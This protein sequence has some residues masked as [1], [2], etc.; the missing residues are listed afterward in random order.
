MVQYLSASVDMYHVHRCKYPIGA[1][2]WLALYK[3]T[4]ELIL[5]T[6][7]SN[8]L[9]SFNESKRSI[10][11]DTEPL[12]KITNCKTAINMK[13]IFIVRW[14][15]QKTQHSQWCG[16][17]SVFLCICFDLSVGQI[18]K[19]LWINMNKILTDVR[20]WFRI[21]QNNSTMDKNGQHLHG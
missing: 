1:G 17:Y 7:V 2:S 14:F 8:I 19:K 4:I 20:I 18:T 16:L 10:D 5:N 6:I 21:M 3:C 13:S 15:F 9:C 11:S 12:K